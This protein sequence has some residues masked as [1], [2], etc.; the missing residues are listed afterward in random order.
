M[1]A[2]AEELLVKETINQNDIVRLV[3]DRPFPIDVSSMKAS[4]VPPPSLNTSFPLLFCC[5]QSG[6]KQYLESGWRDEEDRK[7]KEREEA[8]RNAPANEET[9]KPQEP[10]S[11]SNDSSGDERDGPQASRTKN[12]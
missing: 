3:G 8:L 10:D 4:P 7:I 9:A 12:E 1:K 2:I 5:F 11:D 6:V